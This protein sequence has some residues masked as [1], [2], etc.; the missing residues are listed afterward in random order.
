MEDVLVREAHLLW[1]GSSVVGHG[2]RSW[3]TI[4][5]HSLFYRMMRVIES[6]VCIPTGVVSWSAG[7]KKFRTPLFCAEKSKLTRQQDPRHHA[8]RS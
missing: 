2:E 6:K 3:G 8:S 5:G 4:G 1:S 7:P